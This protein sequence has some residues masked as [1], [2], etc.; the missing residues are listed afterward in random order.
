MPLHFT[1]MFTMTL[2]AET[3]IASNIDTILS[4]TIFVDNWLN[5]GIAWS[6]DGIVQ[7]MSWHP[8]SRMC[9]V[10]Q[11]HL[12]DCNPHLVRWIHAV[13]L[14]IGWSQLI[15]TSWFELLRFS[16]HLLDTHCIGTLPNYPF[17]WWLC[18]LQIVENFDILIF[19]NYNENLCS[20]PLI[21]LINRRNNTGHEM[22][23]IIAMNVITRFRGNITRNA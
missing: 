1:N 16:G 2:N 5:A 4:F 11:D 19:T 15:F 8:H 3:S 20:F 21:I 12:C 14:L 17:N 13:L 10:H 23:I 7:S 6:C 18:H 22:Y 9:D